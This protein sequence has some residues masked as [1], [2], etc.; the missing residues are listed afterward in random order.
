MSVNCT[1]TL[2]RDP[3]KLKKDDYV[4]GIEWYGD[5]SRK[6]RGWLNYVLIS[7]YGNY[8]DI[9]ADD[10]LIR[11]KGTYFLGNDDVFKIETDKPRP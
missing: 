10:D 3:S 2:V 1:R 4:E 6:V 8:Y 11:E 5:K 7:R 9:Q